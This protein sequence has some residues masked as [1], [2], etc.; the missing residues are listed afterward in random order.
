MEERVEAEAAAAKNAPFREADRR[1][2]Y[3][4]H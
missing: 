2:K 3:H 4:A 1:N